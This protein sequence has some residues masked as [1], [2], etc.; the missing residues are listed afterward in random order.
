MVPW[1][2]LTTTQD[3][4]AFLKS[5][6]CAAVR[7]AEQPATQTWTDRPMEEGELTYARA[8]TERER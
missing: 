3:D 4:A 1:F 6:V 2:I 7:A 8:N 5:C